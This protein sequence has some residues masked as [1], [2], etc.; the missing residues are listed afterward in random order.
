MDKFR[1][2]KTKSLPDQVFEQLIAQIV[3]GELK[4]GESLPAERAL[5]EA[6]GVNRHGVREATKR[7]E[8]AGLVKVTQGGG[9]RVLD[10][11]NTGGLDLLSVLTQHEIRGDVLADIWLA[12]LEMRAV[13]GSDAA[14]LCAIRGSEKIKDNLI[15]RAEQMASVGGDPEVMVLDQHFWETILEG[16]GNI[17]Y[18]LAFNS[19][20]RGSEESVSKALQFLKDELEAGDFRRPIAAAIAS[21]DVQLAQDVTREALNRPVLELAKSLGRAVEG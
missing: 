20:I 5:A 15:H 3:S 7:L 10:F 1:A 4:P 6:F 12:S 11:T 9:T 8:Q 16:A 21:G 19:L 13:V 2:I 18:R 14:R 17:A